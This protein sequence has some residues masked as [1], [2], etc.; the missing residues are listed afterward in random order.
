[1]R[2]PKILHIATHGYFNPDEIK[3]DETLTG[4][5]SEYASN[6]LLRSGLLMK[7][8]G[9]VLKSNNSLKINS[10]NGVLTAYEA[11]DLNLDNTDLVVL[12][13]CE[14]GK[15]EVQIGE[16]VFGLQRAILVSGAKTLVMTLFKVN[17]DITKE[18]MINFYKKWLETGEL[19]K[20]FTD[21]KKQIKAKYKYPVYWGSFVMV[22]LE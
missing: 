16:G 13:A 7:G 21:A 11:M 8:A 4:A 18:L 5:E 6:P 1:M 9:D 15:G 20:S 19:R 10:E 2:S 14:T 3:S 22:G 17:D 12:S